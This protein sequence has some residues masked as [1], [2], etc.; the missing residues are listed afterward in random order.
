MRKC[1]T[2]TVLFEYLVYSMCVPCNVFR[3]FVVYSELCKFYRLLC[4]YFVL[5][6]CCVS[7][8]E[9]CVSVLYRV[10]C[11]VLLPNETVTITES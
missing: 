1:C 4:D 7:L 2:I 10:A 5:S 8:D 3:E 9:C 11:V 6:V